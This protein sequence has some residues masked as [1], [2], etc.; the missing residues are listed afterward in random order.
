MLIDLVLFWFGSAN[1]SLKLTYI[2]KETQIQTD[3]NPNNSIS[4]VKSLKSTNTLYFLISKLNNDGGEKKFKGILLRVR[5][6]L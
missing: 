2:Y 4:L 3:K 1:K 5:V 6:R